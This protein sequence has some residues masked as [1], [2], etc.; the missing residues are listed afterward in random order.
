MNGDW[1]LDGVPASMGFSTEHLARGAEETG[2]AIKAAMCVPCEPTYYP[3]SLDETWDCPNCG[4]HYTAYD[5]KDPIATGYGWQWIIGH[6]TE[7][8][9]RA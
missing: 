6:F 8:E 7:E 4:K 2:R 9:R 3:A 5:P 1:S